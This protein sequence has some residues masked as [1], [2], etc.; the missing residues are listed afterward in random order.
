VGQIVGYA[1]TA[2]GA[3]HAFM[4]TGAG[5]LDSRTDDLGTLGGTF[6]TA[7]AINDSGWVVGVSDVNMFT[8]HAFLHFG[9][10]TLNPATDDLGTLGGNASGANDIN[11]NGQ[12]VGSSDT[13]AYGYPHAFIYYGS[14][15]IQDLNA[16]IPPNSGL[17]LTTANG[18]NDLGQIVGCGITVDGYG[19]AFLLT[20]VPEPSTLALLAAAV[21]A[22]LVYGLRQER[23]R[24]EGIFCFK[25]G[26]RGHL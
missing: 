6:S 11:N 23:K 17:T 13:T 9:S 18:I 25:K 22:L 2:S 15:P 19:H 16:L 20:P 14:G 10:G 3:Y 4:H 21:S 5:Y 8:S 26:K 24:G 1:D 7:V 12:V